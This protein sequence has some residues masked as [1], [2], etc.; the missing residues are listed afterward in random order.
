MFHIDASQLD[1]FALPKRQGTS[2]ILNID[3]K[4]KSQSRTTKIREET[5]SATVD[6]A[7]EQFAFLSTAMGKE[8][9]PTNSIIEGTQSA[10][11]SPTAATQQ[12]KARMIN[13]NNDGKSSDVDEV[14]VI[15]A[16]INT[17]DDAINFFARFGSE[18]PV[19]F[20]HLIQDQDAKTYS[21]YELKVT[22]LHD[23]MV[24]HYTMSSAGI[25]HVCP[26]EPSECIPL[27]AWMRQGMMFKILRNI[28]FYKTYLHRKAFSVWRDNVR[29]LLFSKQR[30]KIV[31]R[32]F[33]AKTN[34]CKSILDCKK[35]LIDV[36][37]VKLLNLD[38]KTCDKDVFME[39][40]SAQC[41]KA[42]VKFD[43]AMTSVCNEVKSVIAEVNNLYNTS[44]QHAN[45][46]PLGYG[47]G[48]TEKAKSLVKIKQEKAEK[49]LLRQRAK[50]EHSTLPEFIRL[51]DYMSVET[52]VALAIGTSSSFFEELTKTRKAGVFETMVRFSSIGTT[53]SPTCQEI[54]EML[55]RL[56]DNMIN[57]AGNVSRVNYLQTNK[58]SSSMGPN[59]QTIIRENKQFRETSERIQQRVVSD[60]D[61]AEEHAQS[62]ESVRPIYDFNVSWNFEAYRAQYH[63]ISSLKSMLE[64]I[65]NWSKELEKLRNRPIGILEV[66]SKR[67]KGELNP[68][69]EARLQE[70][71]EYIKDTAR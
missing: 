13:R 21:P 4:R 17:S 57:A 65:G 16:G 27:S 68:L 50:L 35:L 70:I 56:L 43:N 11:Q 23:P 44:K 18:T 61:K 41:N 36:Q 52:L 34:A 14:S 53:F 7:Q 62:Y 33:Y 63:D 55:D 9:R 26:G 38:L 28:P 40:Q 49:K 32:L 66:D 31:D 48:V 45:A 10:A 29:Y 12:D 42:N 69:R 25:V 8:P 39:Q 5:K 20:V 30:K 22:Q 1:T 19:K 60:F 64:L 15:M 51:M 24:E 37:S 58:T 2:S 3:S 54:S 67:L 47:D 6:N 59:I 46:N 71:K